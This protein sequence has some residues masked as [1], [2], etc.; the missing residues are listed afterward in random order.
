MTTFSPIQD[1]EFG[2]EE[3]DD[4]VMRTVI[5]DFLEKGLVE[6][7]VSLCRQEPRQIAVSA[8]LVADERL[9][10]RLGLA[11]LFEELQGHCQKE[12]HR[13]IPVLAEYCSHPEAWVRGEAA[14]LLFLTGCAEALLLVQPLQYDPAPQVA[15]LAREL[16]DDARHG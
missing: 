9:R 10:V 11:V 15:E 2:Y 14:T 16:L 12:L 6:N 7:M 1:R 3:P 5:A 13:A 8:A 4:E